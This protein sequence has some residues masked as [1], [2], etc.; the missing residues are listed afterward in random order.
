MAKTFLVIDSQMNTLEIP[1]DDREFRMVV[2]KY[3]N[4]IAPHGSRNQLNKAIDA[5]YND[6]PKND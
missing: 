5:Y 1:F 3:R 2:E 4:S 6:E